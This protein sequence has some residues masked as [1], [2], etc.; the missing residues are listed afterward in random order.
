MPAWLFFAV[1]WAGLPPEQA[2]ERA[3]D[4]AEPPPALRAAF[5]ATLTSGNATRMIQFDPYAE[6]VN[7]FKLTYYHGDN[8]ELDAVVKGW[9]DETDP[10][11]RLFAEDL[12][13]SL[14][15]ARIAGTEDSMAVSFRHRMSMNDGPIDEQF[16]ARMSGL[17]Q[18]DKRNGHVSRI[19]YQ[20]DSPVKLDNGTTVEEY[21]QTY[22]FAYSERWGVSFVI[23]YDLMARGGRWGMSEERAIKVVLTDVAFGFAGDA[24]Q[25]LQS[26]PAPYNP[27]PTAILR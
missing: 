2:L 3:L 14:G 7:R 27:G 22:N 15:D 4:A 24:K 25:G 13:L 9:M 17:L 23:G 20:I 26:K 5:N 10:D 21:R 19:Q 12:R 16:S 8:E 1:L 6:G 11:S 18:L